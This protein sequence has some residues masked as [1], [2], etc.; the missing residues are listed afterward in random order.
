M[1]VGFVAAGPRAAGT[2]EVLQVLLGD[3]M[4]MEMFSLLT[5]VDFLVN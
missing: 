3:N 4:G 1:L 5:G 2:R